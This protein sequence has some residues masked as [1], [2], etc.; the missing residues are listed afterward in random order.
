MARKA[1]STCT[2]TAPSPVFLLRLKMALERGRV[3]RF[4][5]RGRCCA[6]VHW[7]ARTFPAKFVLDSSYVTWLRIEDGPRWVDHFDA[8]QASNQMILQFIFYS[9]MCLNNSEIRA[10][11]M[12]ASDSAHSWRCWRPNYPKPRFF[13]PSPISC[14]KWLKMLTCSGALNWN[15][16]IY[17]L[18]CRPRVRKIGRLGPLGS[19]S[20]LQECT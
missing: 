8:H 10:P 3:W 15:E 14:K 4:D 7:L 11:E 12:S 18:S 19:I 16:R 17:C 6:P 2:R 5:H 1:R 20:R 13:S 9:W